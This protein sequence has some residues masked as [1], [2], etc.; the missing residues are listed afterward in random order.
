MHV[1]LL[2][3]HASI[4]SLIVLRAHI[5][6]EHD[7]LKET[8]AIHRFADS[9]R[10]PSC[11]CLFIY[12][13]VIPFLEQPE[14]CWLD[15]QC[16]YNHHYIKTGDNRTMLTGNCELL[17]VTTCMFI[18]M[19]YMDQSVSCACLYICACVGAGGH[20]H[21]NIFDLS[22]AP[23]ARCVGASVNTRPSIQ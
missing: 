21:I 20:A 15:N 18:E 8:P 16:N 11:I 12:V 19:I 7:N 22:I 10:Q 14:W 17:D 5:L 3:T 13:V 2:P 6:G 1:L 9:I 4:H 23:A